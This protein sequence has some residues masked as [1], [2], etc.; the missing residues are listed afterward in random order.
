MLLFVTT[1]QIVSDFSKIVKSTVEIILKPF[2][3]YKIVEENKTNPMKWFFNHTSKV[4]AWKIKNAMFF[5]NLTIKNK[6]FSYDLWEKL[7]H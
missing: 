7:Q 4:N 5:L 6:T 3:N 2:S 1:L